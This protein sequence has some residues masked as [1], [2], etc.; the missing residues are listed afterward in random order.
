MEKIK[1]FWEKVTG[2]KV[3]LVLF[4]FGLLLVGFFLSY[5]VKRAKVKAQRMRNLARA[6]RARKGMNNSTKRKRTI[7]RKSAQYLQRLKNLAKARR[8]KKAKARA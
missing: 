7:P 5:L 8:A 3:L 6:R 4:F 2:N 1:A